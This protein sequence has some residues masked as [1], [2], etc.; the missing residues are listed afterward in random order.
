ME[1]L[2]IWLIIAATFG[3]IEAFL[4]DMFPEVTKQFHKKWK[5]DIHIIFGAVRFCFWLPLILLSEEWILFIITSLFTFAFIHDGFYYLFRWMLSNG[6]IYPKTFFDQSQ[7]TT[8]LISLSAFWRLVL[9]LFGI[10]M[11]F[12]L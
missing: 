11:S 12:A 5:F 6:K 1:E 3:I 7:T 8:A 10:G 4:F 9:F 2:I